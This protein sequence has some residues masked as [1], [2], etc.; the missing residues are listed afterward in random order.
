[1]TMPVAATTMP[2]LVMTMMLNQAL[3]GAERGESP[4]T[5]LFPTLSASDSRVGRA[6]L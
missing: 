4:T 3:A 2:V 5:T 1:M 6:I